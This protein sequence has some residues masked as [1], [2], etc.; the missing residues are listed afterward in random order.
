[1]TLHKTFIQET[2]LTDYTYQD[3]RVKC[4]M[5]NPAPV[6]ENVTQKLLGDFDIQT[7]NLISA[8]RPTVKRR[9]NTS[10]LQE[11]L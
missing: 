11:N 2:M 5:H 1:M 4:Y 10:S 9:T 6:L 3:K 8:R 7:D